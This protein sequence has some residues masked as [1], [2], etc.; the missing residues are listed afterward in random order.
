MTSSFLEVNYDV[1]DDFIWT[2]PGITLI[3]LFC[4]TNTSVAEGESPHNAIA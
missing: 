2:V 4:E 1:K 3:I